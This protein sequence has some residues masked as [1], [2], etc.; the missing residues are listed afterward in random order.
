MQIS[1][2][3]TLPEDFRRVDFLA[4]H[5]RDNQ[6]LAERWDTT[7]DSTQCF[8]KGIIWNSMPS[9]LAFN[10]SVQN[11]VEIVLEIDSGRKKINTEQTQQQLQK[12]AAHMLGLNQPT[13]EFEAFAAKHKDIKKL[14][15][16]QSGLRVPQAASPFEAISWAIIGQQI[17][18]GAATSLRRKLIQRAGIQHSSGIYCYPQ[19]EQILVLTEDDLRA[20]S[21]SAT[22]AKTLLALANVAQKGELPLQVWLDDFW[23]GNTLDAE[24]IYAQLIAIRG[25][26]PWTIHYALL[27]GFGWMDGSLHGDVAVRRN[28]QN[29]LT[30]QKKYSGA[31]KISAAETELWLAGFSPWRALV[32][33]HLWAMQKADGY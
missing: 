6:M 28:L 27:R 30:A 2:S 9:R 31:E 20:C 22:K 4:F 1:L 26:G 29:L 32:A 8:D 21:F 7:D 25:I 24:T 15:A 5:Q 23:N 19:P 18:L 13:T 17:S 12:L 3:I 11:Q 14:I 33:A 10:F 16:K